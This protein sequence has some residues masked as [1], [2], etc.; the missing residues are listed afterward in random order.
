MPTA[1]GGHR[2]SGPLFPISVTP[3]LLLDDHEW[4]GRQ[5]GETPRSRDAGDLS[6]ASNT[7]SS[8]RRSVGSYRAL[9]WRCRIAPLNRTALRGSKLP[10]I[11]RVGAQHLGWERATAQRERRTDHR[12]PVNQ[13]VCHNRMCLESKSVSL[14]PGGRIRNLGRVRAFQHRQ[15]GRT[16]GTSRATE[17]SSSDPCRPAR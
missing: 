10:R 11:D 15:R 9:R 2:P 4:R 13:A 8:C 12:G 17:V 3:L 1:S 7:P 16:I 5:S 6:S 14:T